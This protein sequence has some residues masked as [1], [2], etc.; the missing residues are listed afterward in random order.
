LGKAE[1]R[2][3]EA[4]IEAMGSAISAVRAWEA[5]GFFE[6]CGYRRVCQLL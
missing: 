1:A 2:T 3:K 4:L 6:H 5:A